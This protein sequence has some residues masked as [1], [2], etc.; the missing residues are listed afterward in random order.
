MRKDY[1]SIRDALERDVHTAG[2]PWKK[3][4]P[5][6]ILDQG[7]TILL[8]DVKLFDGVRIRVGPGGHVE[9]GDYSVINQRTEIH[10]KKRV[11]IG[12]FCLI[13]WD[14]IIM[15]TDYH[16]IGTSPPVS[17]PTTIEDGV[18]VGNGAII[19]KG[20]TVGRGAVVAAGSVVTKNVPPF[21]I[22][23]GNPA[24]TI[25]KID[26]F[27]GRHGQLY[28]PKWYDPS[29]VPKPLPEEGNG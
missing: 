28:E 13:S 11:V 18:W 17:L 20:L 14:I 27:E 12:R 7:G 23:G 3:I 29:F 8:G 26:P 15:D 1:R 6:W 16:G 4:G 24:K 21:T 19:T 2:F 10:C 9:V 22:V 5:L 25:R